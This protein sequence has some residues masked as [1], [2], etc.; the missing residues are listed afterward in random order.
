MKDEFYNNAEGP[1][2]FMAQ[3]SEFG[4]GKMYARGI[5]DDALVKGEDKFLQIVSCN[6]H[7]IAVLVRS[8]A[9]D[10]DGTN[11]LTTGASS[12]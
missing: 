6:T 12:A 11:H 10:A 4:F 9:M 8:L 7:N 5:N 1:I 2:G 3:G